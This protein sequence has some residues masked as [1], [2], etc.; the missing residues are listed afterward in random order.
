MICI[1]ATIKVKEGKEGLFEEDFI[2]SQI[3]TV[4]RNHPMYIQQ[5]NYVVNIENILNT[6]YYIFEE[7]Y[8]KLITKFNLT[9]NIS[10][11]RAF[12]L[13]WIERQSLDP[14]KHINY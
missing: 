14:T 4:N 1:L 2:K 11:V 13:S 3:D 7:E 5:A 8:N 10:S 9:T 6:D 12:I